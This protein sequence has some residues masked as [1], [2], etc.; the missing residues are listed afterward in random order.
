MLK[1]VF[2]HG[3]LRK[4]EVEKSNLSAARLRTV[5]DPIPRTRRRMARRRDDATDACR[6]MPLKLLQLDEIA[7]DS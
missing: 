6:E 5:N 1:L 3:K 4:D 7:S 2:L